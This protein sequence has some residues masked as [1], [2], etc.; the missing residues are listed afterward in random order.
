[1]GK[2]LMS[3][4]KDRTFELLFYMGKQD[5]QIVFFGIV[6]SVKKFSLKLWWS[7]KHQD[8]SNI[9]QRINFAFKAICVKTRNKNL[10]SEAL[11]RVYSYKYL[12]K[13]SKSQ[14]IS[15]NEK[16]LHRMAFDRNPLLNIFADK[17]ASRKYV[18]DLGFG[19]HLIPIIAIADSPKEIFWENLP[20]EFVC[21]VSHGS[22]GLIGI[23]GGMESKSKLPNDIS[24]LRWQR[25]WVHPERFE[26]S[27]AAGMLEK[28]VGMNYE[29]W[30]GRSPEWAYKSI[31]PQ[32]IIE[33]LL[34]DS[35]LK[36]A[37]QTQFYVFHGQVKL[38]R[39][40][41]R[42]LD[43]ARTMT[44]FSRDWKKQDIRFSDGNKFVQSEFIPPK[45]RRLNEMIEMSEKLGIPIDFVRVDLYS[46]NDEIRFGEMTIYPSAGEGFWNPK[47]FSRDLGAHW[48]INYGISSGVTD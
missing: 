1:M 15:F 4:C 17:V 21:K 13:R 43:G 20:H 5:I 27:K 8:F 37:T 46:F 23:Y 6:D 29:W 30:P 33:E 14:P 31:K 35:N 19:E 41:G 48:K 10:N 2:N 34:V 16:I 18:E 32:I 22:G 26:Y 12:E 40:S 3:L 24:N 11:L 44:Y 28:W 38:I 39:V 9:K 7:L 45:P 36:I 47:S 25:Y 42:N